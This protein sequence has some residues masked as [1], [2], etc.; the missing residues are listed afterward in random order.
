MGKYLWICILLISGFLLSCGPD[1]NLQ[2]VNMMMWQGDPVINSYMK[3]YVVPELKKQG[4]DLQLVSGQGTEIVSTLM[5][6]IEAGKTDSEIDVVWVNG[7]TF[8][9]LKQINGLYGPIWDSLSNIA[10]VD[11]SSSFIKYDF[12]QLVNGYEAPWGTI[13]M[14]MIHDEKRAPQPPS[15]PKALKEWVKANPGKFT[16]S[17]DFT[18]MSF[19]KLLLIEFAGGSEAIKGPFQ[20]DIYQQAGDSLWNYIREIQPY[21]WRKGETFPEGLAAMHR[22]F[23]NGEIDLSIS[24]NDNGVDN[25][26]LEGL[27]PPSAKGYAW[28]SGIIKNSHFLGIPSRSPHKSGALKTINF[29]LSPEAQYKKLQP[30]GWGDGTSLS[31][32]LLPEEWKEKFRSTQQRKQ[33]PPRSEI[34]QYAVMEPAPEY[35]IRLYDDF[36]KKIIDGE[37]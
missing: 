24:M 31:L 2:Q 3:T 23:A 1:Q 12:Q 33:T 17:N 13:Q 28:K 5:T 19:L 8:F 10:Y 21:F 4:I 30:D 16:L 25:K 14:I 36:A 7:E 35:M 18:G 6:E 37:E 29:L 27:F 34:E 20:S 9:Q 11:T 26:V 15:N 32:N 22:L